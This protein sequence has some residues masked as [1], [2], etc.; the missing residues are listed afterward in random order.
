MADLPQYT[1]ASYNAD[2]YK[3][4]DE[5]MSEYMMRLAKLRAQ[6]ILGGGGMLDTPTVDAT[7]VDATT[8]VPLGQVIKN[9]VDGNAASAIADAEFLASMQ[10]KPA[11]RNASTKYGLTP[12]WM[13]GAAALVPFPFGLLA[14]AGIVLNDSDAIK[15]AQIAANIPE[16]QRTGTW[17]KGAEDVI[18][19]RN[20]NDKTYQV[21]IGGIADDPTNS[22]IENLFN[23]GNMITT[24]TPDEA[25]RRASSAQYRSQPIAYAAPQIPMTTGMLTGQTVTPDMS[26]YIVDTGSGLTT[27]GSYNDSGDWSWGGTDF[28][29]PGISGDGSDWNSW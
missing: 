27:S 5:T 25:R 20:I 6:G 13:K 28:S 17:F 3:K 8:S 7:Q 18:G 9:R 14:G 29:D 21:S 11:V 10:G 4:P 19:S 16:D 2:M 22:I 15:A 26:N 1:G 12:D 23:T 24:L